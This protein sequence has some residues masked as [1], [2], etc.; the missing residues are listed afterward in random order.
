[1]TF[2]H[3]TFHVHAFALPTGTLLGLLSR[4]P[5]DGRLRAHMPVLDGD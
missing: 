3:T 5:R 4:Q 1:M 2:T